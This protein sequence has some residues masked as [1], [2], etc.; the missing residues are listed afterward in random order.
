MQEVNEILEKFTN[1]LSA[2]LGVDLTSEPAELQRT[3]DWFKD[4]QGLFTGSAFKK[5][6]TCKSRAKGKTWDQKKWLMDFGDTAITYI[7][8]RAIER[9]TGQR[10]E[11]PTTWEMQWGIDHEDEGRE[12]VANKYNL[13]VEEVGFEKFLSNAGA[14]ADGKITMPIPNSNKEVVTAFELKCPPKVTNHVKYL[15]EAVAEGHEYFWQLQGEMLALN[16]DNAI[17]ASYHPAFPENFQTEMQE[18][19]LSEVHATALIFR[20]IIAEKLVQALMVDIKADLAQELIMIGWEIP[21]EYEQL[22][23]WIDDERSLL[24]I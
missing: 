22:K 13:D 7:V 21:E 16:T 9:V 20:C 15:R 1:D 6:M 5:L 10:I 23:Q 11:T 4:R 18:V 3:D 17:F 19:K 14:S 12:A 2:K 8:E 24:A